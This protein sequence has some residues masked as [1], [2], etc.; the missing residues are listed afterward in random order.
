MRLLAAERPWDCSL[1]DDGADMASARENPRSR[2]MMSPSSAQ[3]NV[4]SSP[5]T[6]HER[7]QYGERSEITIRIG[8][9]P[10]RR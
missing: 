9:G 8:G 2:A 6:P 7:N 10:T 1:G 4:N 5:C 3:C